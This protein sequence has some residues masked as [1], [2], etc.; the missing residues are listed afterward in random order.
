MMHLAYMQFTHAT[1]T[2]SISVSEEVR[3]L[4]TIELLPYISQST[5]YTFVGG[6]GGVRVMISWGM[7]EGLK[8]KQLYS[9]FTEPVP[10]CFSNLRTGQGCQ[11]LNIIVIY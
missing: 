1:V 4:W 8:Q 2:H 3:T 7:L 11:D 9:S 10:C 5:I 6:S